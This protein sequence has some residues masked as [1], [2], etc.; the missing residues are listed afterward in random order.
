MNDR[1]QY[2]HFWSYTKEPYINIPKGYKIH[3]VCSDRYG[4]PQWLILEKE[5]KND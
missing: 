2:V 3:T 4:A 1:Y 5:D